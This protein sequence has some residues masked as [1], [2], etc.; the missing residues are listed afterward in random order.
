MSDLARGRIR[1]TG[2]V[3]GVGFRY[4]ARKS[5]VGLGLRGYVRNRADGSV[6]VLAEGPREDVDA[7]MDQLRVGPRY[8]SVDDVDVTWEAP[9]GNLVGFD[10]AF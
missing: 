2:Y 6:E 7:L 8:A 4:F 3:Q 5:A 1:I 9:K 10:Y